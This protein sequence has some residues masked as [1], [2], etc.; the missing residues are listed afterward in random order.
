MN[1]DDKII[2][3]NPSEEP[4]N[5]ARGLTASRLVDILDLAENGS[6]RELFALYRDVLCDN[7]VQSEFSKR[8]G[9]ILGD[10]RNLAPFDKKRP[11][12]VQ[13][14]ELCWPLVE[15][16]A[17][18]DAISWMLNATL[19]PVAVCEKIF[20]PLPSGFV[21]R[22]I[23]PVPFQMLDL[24]KSTV[25]IFDV[26]EGRIQSTSR[27]ADPDRYIIHRGHTLPLPDRWGGPMRALLFWWLL[28]TM[29]RQWWASL[30]ERFGTP[31]LKG[32]YKDAPGR[33][34][35]E[36]AF[37]LATKIG[38]IVLSSGTKAEVVSAAAGQSTDSHERF[39]ELCNREIA[40]LVSG[41]TLASNVQATGMG[42]GTANLQGAVREDVRKMDV[43]LLAMTLRDQLFSQYCR[44]N[45]SAGRPPIV[46]FGS[47]SAAELKALFALLTSL[48]AAG[49]EPDDDGMA[50][51]GERFG[52]GI[53][54][55]ASMPGLPFNAIGLSSGIKDAVAPGVSP[56]LSAAFRGHLA[57]VAKIIRESVSQTDCLA[58]VRA[59]VL[60]TGVSDA[61]D[62]IADAL[63]AYALSGANSAARVAPKKA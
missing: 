38:G 20:D 45:G 11:D 23:R 62:L 7:R 46:L 9:A 17:F 29:D 10:T 43:A 51:I 32:E 48:G 41:Q 8:K 57:P 52:F 5:V 49:F 39:V 22:T 6:T 27:Q 33:A 24:S 3:L 36:R 55:K 12:D 16:S 35:L 60:S 4:S 34:V 63:A 37:S 61:P 56:D 50:V 26:I 30:L 19:Y 25:R 58:K 54:R 14:K 18:L 47:D 28:R 31:F 59:W 42:D 13:A 53:R 40:F 2:I 15:S 21:L 44:I 1:S